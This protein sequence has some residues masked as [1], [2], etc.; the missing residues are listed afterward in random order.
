MITLSQNIILFVED[1]GKEDAE[2]LSDDVQTGIENYSNGAK[3][4]LRV[5][6]DFLTDLENNL[7]KQLNG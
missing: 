1:L 3:T 2:D 6:I 7:D 5:I 4:S